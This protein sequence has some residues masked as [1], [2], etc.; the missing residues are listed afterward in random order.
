MEY[1]IKELRF[2]EKFIIDKEFW[3]GYMEIELKL[4]KIKYKIFYN[5]GVYFFY[6]DNFTSTFETFEE[7]KEFIE[8]DYENYMK[9]I[10]NEYLE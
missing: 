3:D 8:K 7:M 6:R 10:I 9:Q 1:K 4:L 2:P 5:Q